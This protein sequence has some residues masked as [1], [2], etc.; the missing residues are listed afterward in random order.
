MVRAARPYPG[1]CHLVPPPTWRWPEGSAPCKGELNMTQT[2]GP[3]ITGINHS[4]ATV[5]DLEASVAWYQQ[6]FGLDRVPF[7]FRHYEREETGYGIVLMDRAWASRSGCTP[8]RPTGAR[9][10]M[11]AAPGWTTSPSASLTA[12][13]WRPG[14]LGSMSSASSTPA[15]GTRRSPWHTPRWCSG[16]PTTSSSSSSRSADETSDARPAQHDQSQ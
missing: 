2:A 11:S 12:M 5:T 9:P 7:D 13:S 4:S 1:A 6:L 10:S 8:T 3:R 16:T 14:W 15:S